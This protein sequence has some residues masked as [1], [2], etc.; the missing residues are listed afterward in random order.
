[1]RVKR[2]LLDISLVLILLAICFDFNP[3]KNEVD[4]DFTITDIN[5]LTFKDL[6]R[7]QEELDLLLD[8]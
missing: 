7:S 8:Y 1:M 5:R 4:S 6:A 2:V 3:E